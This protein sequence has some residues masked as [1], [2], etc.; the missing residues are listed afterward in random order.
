MSTAKPN[1]SRS[2]QPP[3]A[4]QRAASVLRDM[5]MTREVGELLGSEE[6]LMAGLGVSRPTL[7]QAAALVAQDHLI[8]IRRGVNGGYFAAL[9][10]SMTVARMAA[11]YLQSRKAGLA[12][13]IHAVDPI[14]TEL[15][16]L[17]SRN[18]DPEARQ[19]LEAF[20]EHEQ[21]ADDRREDYRAFLRAE[22]AFGRVLG[23][24]S[25][26]EVLSLFLG[27]VYDLSALIGRDVDVYHNRPERVALY[28]AHRNRM[29]AAILEGDEELAVLATKRCTAIVTEWMQEDMAGHGFA[30]GEGE[31]ARAGPR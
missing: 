13:V 15:A 19:K 22:R 26:S 18:R 16:R 3:S 5:A 17:A 9:P 29:A 25:G 20:L 31:A 6:E 2:K 27:I 14:R 12:E 28:R 1:P 30:G 7:R 11:I 10:S 24:M 21:Q 8:N 4:V 23:A